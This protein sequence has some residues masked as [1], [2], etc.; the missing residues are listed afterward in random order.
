V[1]A[2][3]SL[4]GNCYIDNLSASG[5][6]LTLLSWVEV[7]TVLR[8]RLFSWEQLVAHEVSLRV[9][10]ATGIE[11]GPCVAGGKFEQPLPPQVL[12]ALLR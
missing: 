12:Q 10:H 7:G 4:C 2:P 3:E 5:A 8:L 6:C 9:I 1:L 11:G